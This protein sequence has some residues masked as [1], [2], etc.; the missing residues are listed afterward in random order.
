M[1]NRKGSK[2][3]ARTTKRE[4]L[5]FHIFPQNHGKSK[6]ICKPSFWF[7]I[8][9]N[10]FPF[11]PFVFRI[12]PLYSLTTSCFHVFLMCARR[13]ERFQII[14]INDLYSEEN[15][16]V[17][18]FLFSILWFLSFAVTVSP[19][20][21]QL[22]GVIVLTSNSS[23]LPHLKSIGQ[24]VCVPRWG[25]KGKMAG[26]PHWFPIKLTFGLPLNHIRKQL[27]DCVLL[28]VYVGCMKG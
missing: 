24:D 7:N 11:F 6:I 22:S 3:T 28:E 12:F 26:F 16:F 27:I 20:P 8:N 15:V 14:Q 21:S 13:E 18:F 9:R 17:I 5:I 19:F 4:N 23:Q 25:T 2:K 1:V 10:D